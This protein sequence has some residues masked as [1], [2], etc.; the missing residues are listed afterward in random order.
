MFPQRRAFSILSNT[1]WEVAGAATCAARYYMNVGLDD[2]EEPSCE[3]IAIDKLVD[4]LAKG[5]AMG[6]FLRKHSD[7]S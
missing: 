6:K 7:K 4:E 2:I 3:K 1:N 5:R